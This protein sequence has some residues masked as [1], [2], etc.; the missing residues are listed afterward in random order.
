MYRI[1]PDTLY[2]VESSTSLQGDEKEKYK[3]TVSM[4]RIVRIIRTASKNTRIFQTLIMTV[5]RRKQ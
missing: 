4:Q 3:C 5:A 2:A 1:L